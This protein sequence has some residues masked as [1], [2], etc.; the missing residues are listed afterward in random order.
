M[1]DT[2]HECDYCG[3]IYPSIKA[4]LLCCQEKDER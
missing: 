2:Q 4:A 1:P 3:A